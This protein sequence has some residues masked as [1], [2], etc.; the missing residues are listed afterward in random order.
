VLPWLAL[1]QFNLPDRTPVLSILVAGTEKPDLTR[2]DCL[3][4][5]PLEVYLTALLTNPRPIIISSLGF[6]DSTR[7]RRQWD[8]RK[9]TRRL[10]EPAINYSDVKRHQR[11]K[12]QTDQQMYGDAFQSVHLGRCNTIGSPPRPQ[13]VDPST[14]KSLP[15]NFTTKMKSEYAE[16]KALAVRKNNILTLYNAECQEIENAGNWSVQEHRRMQRVCRSINDD[17][18]RRVATSPMQLACNK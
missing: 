8:D 7:S 6:M 17:Q 1:Q 12:F 4:T 9:P 11:R 5:T 16:Y 13:V 2:N 14:Y 18:G 10:S 3:V 15:Y